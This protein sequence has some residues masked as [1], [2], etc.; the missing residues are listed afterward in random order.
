[1]DIK[2]GQDPVVE[3]VICPFC[4]QI[5]DMRGEFMP[6]C[7]ED[8]DAIEGSITTFVLVGKVTEVRE[9]RL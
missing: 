6:C 8:R 1:M 5:S 9:E 2:A 3:L 4:G 7:G